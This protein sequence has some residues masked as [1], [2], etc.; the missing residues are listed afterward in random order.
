MEPVLLSREECKQI[1]VNILVEVARICKENGLKYCLAYGTLLGAVRHKGFIPW[2]DDIDIFLMREDY[3]KLAE[4]MKEKKDCE[5][6]DYVDGSNSLNYYYPF[7]K[8]VDNRTLAKQVDNHTEHGIWVDIFPLDTVPLDEKRCAS[9]LRRNQF[10]RN[11][12]LAMTTD[13][14][15]PAHVNKFFAKF[16]LN[17]LAILVGKERLYHY[18]IKYNKKYVGKNT[19]FV[20]CLSTPYVKKERMEK[21]KLSET[22]DLPFEN[23]FFSA[24]K[25]WD[26]YLKKLY[27]DYMQLPPE[28]KRKTHQMIAWKI[29]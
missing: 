13:F 2:D 21:N 28:D 1:Q 3:E 29:R 14:S 4:I 6:L 27:G 5:W 16:I 11:W 25:E 12:I 19:G 23:V 17:L 7:A 24:P 20:A 22:V 9:F 8:A 18:T 10:L 26:W 15:K